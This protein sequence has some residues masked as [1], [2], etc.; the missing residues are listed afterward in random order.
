MRGRRAALIAAATIP[1]GTGR[2]ARVA[3]LR[4]PERIDTSSAL[5]ES[6][7]LQTETFTPPHLLLLLQVCTAV[8]RTRSRAAFGKGLFHRQPLC[9]SRHTTLAQADTFGY[10]MILHSYQQL[11]DLVSLVAKKGGKGGLEFAAKMGID[12]LPK[13][14]QQG[15]PPAALGAGSSA[16][17]SSSSDDAGGHSRQ[18]S[19]RRPWQFNFRQINSEEHRGSLAKTMDV[20]EPRLMSK[21]QHLSLTQMRTFYLPPTATTREKQVRRVR[22]RCVCCPARPLAG[23][24]AQHLRRRTIAPS[25]RAFP[26]ALL[27]PFSLCRTTTLRRASRTRSRRSPSAS[28]STRTSSRSSRSSRSRVQ[29]VASDARRCRCATALRLRLQ[30]RCSALIMSCCA[31]WRPA[32][33]SSSPGRATRNLS[34][35]CEAPL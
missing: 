17:A 27:P 5:S 23:S 11:R 15:V 10:G 20:L 28:T 4:V 19:R 18:G 9:A 13:S 32:S 30:T 7:Q 26:R 6:S 3:A 12:S 35:V 25:S 22:V 24:H 2:A 14:Q 29:H 16:A 21:L 1:I 34:T 8:L 31:R 33:A